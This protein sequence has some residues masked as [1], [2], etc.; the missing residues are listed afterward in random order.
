MIH[1][2]LAMNET[3][4]AWRR[5]RKK[6]EGNGGISALRKKRTPGSRYT[7]KVS[8]FRNVFLSRFLTRDG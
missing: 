1:C 4:K 6:E 5:I 2:D 8:R 3:P 7:I